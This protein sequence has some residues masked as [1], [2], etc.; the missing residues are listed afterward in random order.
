MAKRLTAQQCE[1]RVAALDSCA[2]HLEQIWTDYPEEREQGEV[3]ERWLR[4]QAVKFVRRAAQRRRE[5]GIPP[6]K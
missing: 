3:L 1:A 4:A 6:P 2:D 5:E